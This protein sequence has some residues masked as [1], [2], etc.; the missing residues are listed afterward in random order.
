MVISLLIDYVLCIQRSRRLESFVLTNC[1]HLF[2]S[3]LQIYLEK[4]GGG[5]FF[6]AKNG[7]L[8]FDIVYYAMQY[9]RRAGVRCHTE[10]VVTIFT[11]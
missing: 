8:V 10:S 4:S 3:L 5:E 9:L 11:S 6:L 7:S 1:V 2:I